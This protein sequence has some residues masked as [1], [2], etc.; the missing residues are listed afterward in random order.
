MW[1]QACVIHFALY[2][3]CNVFSQKRMIKDIYSIIQLKFKTIEIPRAPPV[4]WKHA[5]SHSLQKPENT[6]THSTTLLDLTINQIVNFAEYQNPNRNS[7]PTLRKILKRQFLVDQDVLTYT[8]GLKIPSWIWTSSL[9]SLPLTS[10]CA[11]TTYEP[12]KRILEN[13]TTIQIMD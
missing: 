4:F 6:P 13:Q 10:L 1:F 9:P 8:I 5:S 3:G 11:K 7:K 2:S 12:I